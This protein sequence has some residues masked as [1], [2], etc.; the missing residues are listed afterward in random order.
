MAAPRNSER[1]T[2]RAVT[3]IHGKVNAMKEGWMEIDC[4]ECGIDY[5][6]DLGAIECPCG[7]KLSEATAAEANRYDASGNIIPPKP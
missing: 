4:P 2:V 3:R 6:V 1:R 7:H 5:D